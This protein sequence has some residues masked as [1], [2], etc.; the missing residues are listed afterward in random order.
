MRH[1]P[2]LVLIFLLAACNNGKKGGGDVKPP[3]VDAPRTMIY[4]IVSGPYPH[5]TGSYT[6]GLLI[7]KGKLYE[8][9]GNYGFSKLREIDLATGKVTKEIKLDPSIFGEGIAIIN[10][11]IYQLTYKEKKVFVYTL[12]DFKKVK[13]F[14][15]DIEGWGMTTDGKSLILGTGGSSEL[16]FYNPA[17]FQLEKK[18]TV[19]EGGIPVANINELELAGGSIYANQYTTPYILKIDTA[20]WKVVAKAD[21]SRDWDRIKTLRPGVDE[22]N[23]VPNGIAYDPATKKMYI[24]GKWWPELYEVKFG[25]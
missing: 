19:T 13:E 2:V 20:T 23:I 25:E 8:S 10:D 14:T 6:E 12:K 16:S 15:A 17:N 21:I 11:T 4:N 22:G 5:D 3:V 9:T 7:Y 24:T 1:F 18:V